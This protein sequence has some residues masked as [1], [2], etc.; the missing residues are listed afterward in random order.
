[1]GKM[2]SRRSKSGSSARLLSRDRIGRDNDR[3]VSA[4][5]RSLFAYLF[6]LSLAGGAEVNFDLRGILLVLSSVI[7]II[8]A[9]HQGAFAGWPVAP[10]FLKAALILLLAYAI[11]QVVP[12]PPQIWH[13]LPGQTLRTETLAS[14]A[15][16]DSWQPIS[17]TP[18]FSFYSAIMIIGAVVALCALFQLTDHEFRCSAALIALMIGLGMAIGAIQIST[19]GS[20]PRF[21]RSSD[22]ALIGLYANKNHMGLALASSILIAH[23]L[24]AV[25]D[26][27]WSSPRQLLFYAY[28][29]LVLIALPLTNSRA[30]VVFG[31]IVS[32]AVVWSGTVKYDWKVRVGAGATM[33][34]LALVL[35]VSPLPQLLAERFSVI[36]DD[37][38]W[39]IFARSTTLLNPYG[40]F[41]S[42]LGSFRDIFF[43]YEKIEWVEPFYLNNAHNDYLFRL[44]ARQLPGHFF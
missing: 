16:V 41:G 22:D 32:A 10:S 2:S 6:F 27:R 42:G 3:N 37:D 11:L 24:L 19:G 43:T 18:V 7:F 5:C 17:L 44:W 26:A 25:R 36:A 29:V 20:F 13:A 35:A 38:R 4:L 34:I 31:L 28:W 9:A 33:L 21:Y 23:F 14:A 12:L 40:Y 15:L 30:G 1:M 39:E 8:F